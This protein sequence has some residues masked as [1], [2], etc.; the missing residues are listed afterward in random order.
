MTEDF[1]NQYYIGDCIDIIKNKIP[2]NSVNCVITSPPYAM[3]RKTQYGG[4]SE[5]D[6]PAWTV[7][8]MQEIERVLVDDGN[9]AIVIRPHLVKGEISDYMLKT[10]LALRAAG[11]HECEELIW[12]KPDSPPM[13]SFYRPRRGWESIH[14]FSKTSKPFCDTMAN[15][16]RSNRIGMESTKGLGDYIHAFGKSTEGVAR[17]PDY[18]KVGTSRNDKT[19]GN[20]HPAQYPVQLAEWLIK[21]LCPVGGVVLDPFLGSGTTAVAAINTDREWIGCEISVEYEDIIKK[22][23]SEKYVNDYENW[24]SY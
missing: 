23:I 21:L 5:K 9:V 24:I 15:G 4:I 10:R 18:V 22:R 3:Q 19:E 17:A 16:K 12:I 13:G 20:I 14:W 11:W 7:A 6:Y 1:L 8:Y 2:A